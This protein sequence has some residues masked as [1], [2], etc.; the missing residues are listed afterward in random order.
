MNAVDDRR[1]TPIVSIHTGHDLKEDGGMS[2]TRERFCSF[3]RRPISI[4]EHGEVTY[5]QFVDMVDGWCGVIA[6]HGIVAGDRVAL[7][8]DFHIGV[9]AMLQALIDIGC[10]VVPL[11]TDDDNT[12]QERM[13]IACVSWMIRAPSEHA[14]TPDTIAVSR[15]DDADRPLNPMLA[16][17]VNAGAAG[18][19]IFTSG[20]TGKGK[21]VLLDHGRMTGKFI[22]KVRD[23]YRTLLFLK[24]DHIAGLNSLFSVIFNGGAL[25]TC[26]SRLPRDIC[27]S[28]ERYSVEAL[29]TTPSFLTMLRMSAMHREFD[30]SSLKI[31]NYGTE[32]MPESTLK[33]LRE[34]FPHVSLRQGYGLSEMGVVPT[35]SKDS[36]SLWMKIGGFGYDIDIRNGTLWIKSEQTMVG[37]LNAP[38]PFDEDGWY[39]TGDRVV[40][41]GDYIRILGRDSEIINVAGEKVFPTEIENVMLT[42]HNVADVVIRK[43]RSPIVGQMIWAECVLEYEEDH[44]AFKRRVFA[45]CQKLLAPY[46]VPGHITVS[47]NEALVGSRFKKMRL[48]PALSD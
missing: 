6:G 21:A 5:A 16:P 35:K 17:M 12:L 32:V 37:Y 36:S 44:S 26:G 48:A 7:I 39:N 10:I 19:V 38:S 40:V 2:W 46:K 1:D 33:G 41:D 30:L 11:P 28:I 29:P 47:K 27:A 45:E 4:N 9:V 25:I 23:G 42:I 34:I 22:D 18:F 31:I 3:D 13:D 14:C 8:A 20:S 24:L 43:K 15:I